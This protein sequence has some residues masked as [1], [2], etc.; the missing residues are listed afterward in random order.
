MT[1]SI[2]FLFHIAASRADVYK[3]LSTIEGLAGWWTT[4]TKGDTNP[5]G[6]IQ[7]RFGEWGGPDVK[8]KESVKDQHVTWECLSGMAGWAGTSITIALD[9]N[10]GKTRVRFSHD[11]FAE[12][13]DGY[14]STT[15]GWSRY[16]QSLRAF[17][18]TGK[19][20]AFGG[21]NYRP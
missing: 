13:N 3:A 10:E 18:Q 7:F 8:V 14:A 11:G 17:C 1:H 4:D 16:I 15:M 9:E 2:K 19:G 20:E 6:T 5:G 21:P 12:A